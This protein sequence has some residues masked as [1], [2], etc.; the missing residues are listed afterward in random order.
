GAEPRGRGRRGRD[1]RRARARAGGRLEPRRER[2]AGVGVAGLVARREPPHALLRGAVRERLLAGGASRHAR[3]AVVADGRG[4]VEA[5]LHVTRLEHAALVG[6]GGPDAGV[7][8]GLELQRD[9]QGVRLARRGLLALPDLGERA[10]QVLEV[11]TDLVRDHV[12]LRQVPRR[13]EATLQVVVEGEVDVH[14][15]VDRAVERAGGGRGRAA[16]RLD[17]VAEQHQ[18]R[19]G[20][21]AVDELLPRALHVV[22]HERDEADLRLLGLQLLLRN[23][24]A[25]LRARAD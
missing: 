25:D 19:L 5:L 18:A 7:A 22:E 13:P 11:V 21:L 14:G 1:P 3:E 16:A 9:R 24:R 23:G 6:G 15:R 12:R 8:V 10:R 2:V 17:G 20:V 4:R